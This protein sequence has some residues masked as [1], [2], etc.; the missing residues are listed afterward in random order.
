MAELGQILENQGAERYVIG[1]EV[2]E[3]GYEHYQVRV[4]YKTE[5][6]MDWMIK[7][8]GPVG[9]VTPSHVR[10]FKYCEKEGHFFA[11]GKRHSTNSW[12][13]SYCHGSGPF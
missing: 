6:T 4:V 9:H 13:W 3:G 10:D 12:I 5:H 8:W 2:G 11:R 7:V 1:D